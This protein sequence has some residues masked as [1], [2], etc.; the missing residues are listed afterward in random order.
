[1]TCNDCAAFPPEQTIVGQ[2]LHKRLCYALTTTHRQGRCAGQVLSCPLSSNMHNAALH[3]TPS[4]EVPRY[5]CLL[6]CLSPDHFHIGVRVCFR[7]SHLTVVHMHPGV[8]ARA[9][10]IGDNPSSGQSLRKLSPLM[11]R[12]G[13]DPLLYCPAATRMLCLAW[14]GVVSWFGSEPWTLVQ[15]CMWSLRVS[16]RGERDADPE[17]PCFT[18][19]CGVAGVDVWCCV[20]RT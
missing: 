19:A 14:V 2:A 11:Q 18:V 7:T 12:K 1:M 3:C 8:N 5:E 15:C 20:S 4:S 10:F 9:T 17:Q 6:R 16:Y 13:C